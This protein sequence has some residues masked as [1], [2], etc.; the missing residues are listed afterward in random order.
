MK[1]W[2]PLGWRKFLGLRYAAWRAARDKDRLL[3]YLR[4]DAVECNV[5]GWC[6]ARFADDHWHAE[7]VCPV[8]RSQVRHRMFAA[9]LD[10]KSDA[11]DLSES[12]LLAG[13][14][15]LHFAPERQL[16]D[17]IERLAKRYVTADFD[18][19]D[20]DL[21]LDMSCMPEVA[22]ASFDV[23]IACDVLEHVPD[24]RR[25]MREV[26]R[27]LCRSGISILSVPQKDPPSVT[28]EDPVVTDPA[29]RER[30]YG[31][32]DHVRIYGDDFPARLRAEGFTVRDIASGN[33]SSA[34]RERHVLT[35]P[36]PNTHVLATNHRRIYLALAG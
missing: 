23:V 14:R 28:E 2:I 9:M 16:R 35:P 5:C 32:K 25:A 18:R 10:G 24:D 19:G 4:G 15:I 30:R 34:I 36:T 1:E 31:Q 22:D 33:F 3:R 20:C 29:E 17:R 12:A 8:C 13:K 11:V 21:K 6:G 27:I 26:R 7:T